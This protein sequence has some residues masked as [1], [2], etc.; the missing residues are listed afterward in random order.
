[1]GDEAQAAGAVTVEAMLACAHCGLHFPA[2]EA[3]TNTNGSVFCSIE[4]QRLHG[5]S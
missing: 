3:L 1:M 4:H 5:L 2:S